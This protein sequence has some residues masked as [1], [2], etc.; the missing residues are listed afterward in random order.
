MRSKRPLQ[1]AAEHPRHSP[2]RANLPEPLPFF[3]DAMLTKNMENGE[4]YKV[5]LLS[6]VLLARG[7]TFGQTTPK[8]VAS[9][10]DLLAALDTSQ[11]S[12]MLFDFND[13]KQRVR[14]S[15]LPTTMVPRAGLKMG[16]LT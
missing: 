15:N 7:V 13:E 11:R 3:G 14:W 2:V 6:S 16:E 12:R 8:I 4:M 10:N 5:I 1:N 9:A